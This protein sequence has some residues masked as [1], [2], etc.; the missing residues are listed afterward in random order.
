[1]L[2][3]GDIDLALH[4]LRTA[5]VEEVSSFRQL[6]RLGRL[7]WFVRRF[8]FWNALCLSGFKRAKHFGTF[9]MSSLGN[10]GVEQHHPLTPLTTYFTYGPIG[11][12]G[13]VTAKIVYDHR[14]MDGRCVARCL[15]ELEDVLQ[16]EILMELRES[17]VLAGE[18]QTKVEREAGSVGQSRD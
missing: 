18:T 1:T 11:D 16:G 9:M 15:Q 5:P 10:L 14:V 17:S 8:V 3:L 4:Q 6:L 7:P 13:D 12:D 2:P